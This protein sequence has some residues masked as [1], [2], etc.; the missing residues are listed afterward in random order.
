[1]KCHG[2]TGTIR[3]VAMRPFSNEARVILRR[4][5]MTTLSNAI[6]AAIQ[7]TRE[8][9][10][11]SITHTALLN[12]IASRLGYKNYRALVESE[13]SSEP[14]SI[15]QYD[16]QSVTLDHV[17]EVRKIACL[18]TA[19]CSV[20]VAQGL[21]CENRAFLIK[22][23]EY[24]VTYLLGSSASALEI[25]M[26]QAG[27]PERDRS[28]FRTLQKCGYHYVEFDVDVDQVSHPEIPVYTL[29]V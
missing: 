21:R 23:N 26:E 12:S 6:K 2:G 24:G 9:A 3:H 20:E 16:A 8:A 15:S 29:V 13:I 14:S 5:T 7:V 18:S 25:S 10:A 17:L 4:N 1:M 19:H 27:V 28:T 11:S 22:E